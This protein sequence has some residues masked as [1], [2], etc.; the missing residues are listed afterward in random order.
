MDAITRAGLIVTGAVAV[1]VL[2]GL[3]EWVYAISLVVTI[4][5]VSRDLFRERDVVL[6]ERT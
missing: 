5:L 3:P 6:R 2:A 4:A 1:A